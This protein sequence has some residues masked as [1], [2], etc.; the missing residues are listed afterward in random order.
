M[1]DEERIVKKIE[2][3]SRIAGN[4]AGVEARESGQITPAAKLRTS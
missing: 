1:T 3:A 2:V 4:L